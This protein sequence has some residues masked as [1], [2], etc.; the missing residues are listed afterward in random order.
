VTSRSAA[1]GG[2]A[3]IRRLFAFVERWAARRR[4]DEKLKRLETLWRQ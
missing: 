3:D 1:S 2:R 4:I